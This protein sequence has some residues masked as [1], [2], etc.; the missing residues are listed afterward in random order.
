MQS[1]AVFAWHCRRQSKTNENC[2]TQEVIERGS[3]GHCQLD[4]D[5]TNR[6][7]LCKAPVYHPNVITSSFR[8]LF[9]GRDDSERKGLRGSV[10][11][12]RAEEEPSTTYPRTLSIRG[13]RTRYQIFSLR[14]EKFPSRSSRPPDAG[15]FRRRAVLFPERS[16]VELGMTCLRLEFSG[17]AASTLDSHRTIVSYIRP[18]NTTHDG[19]DASSPPS[20]ARS[21]QK[22]TLGG[23]WA[24]SL[25]LVL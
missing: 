11:R 16:R 2:E 23:K 14:P 4:R 13:C 1:V 5:G 25:Q 6:G 12:K 22:R 20:P 15:S 3:H 10:K 21:E 19:R 18:L 8:I 24:S 9:G 7:G 17:T